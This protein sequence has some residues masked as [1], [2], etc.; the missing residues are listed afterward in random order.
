MM[1]RVSAL[2]K[3]ERCVPPSVVLMLLANVKM[4]SLYEEFHCIA[5]S[6][7]P[8]LVSFSRK[9]MLRWMASLSRLM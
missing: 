3:P 5:I 9:M 8:S 4:D 6:T 1:V 2:R 7:A